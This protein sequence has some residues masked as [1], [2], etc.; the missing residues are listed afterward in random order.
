MMNTSPFR[1]LL[2]RRTSRH[3]GFTLVELMIA[4]LLGLIV[5]AGVSSVFLANLRAYHTST[6]LGQVESG[7]RIAYE[8][9]ARD[10]RQAGANGCNSASGRVVNVL[11]NG[12]ASA[13]TV[14]WWADWNNALRGYDDAATDPAGLASATSSSSIGLLF[15]GGSPV[16]IKEDNRGTGFTLYQD[17]DDIE[18]GDIIMVCSPD[19]ATVVQVTGPTNIGSVVNYNHGS[20]VTPGNCTN[21]LGYPTNPSQVCTGNSPMYAF[22]RNSQVSTLHAVD[23]YVADNNA[24][25]TSLYRAVLENDAGIP[26]V[27]S[28]EM[29]RGVTSMNIEYLAADASS[30]YR[31]ANWITAGGYWRNV[32]AVRVTLRLRSRS[33]RASVDGTP[34]ERT[35]SFTTALRNRLK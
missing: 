4:M 5:I 7:S 34:I 9:M 14:A 30:V 28:Y 16:S 20:S 27:N 19:H 1:V 33:D 8:L 26:T 17:T 2:L 22:P 21:N 11:N 12:P 29:V 25:G 23:W 24:G 13:S 35:Y 31:N 18:K 6:A 10:I 32:T 15:A 3:G